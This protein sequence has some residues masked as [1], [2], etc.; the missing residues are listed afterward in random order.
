MAKL[1][2]QYNKAKK[3]IIVKNVPALQDEIKELETLKR[4]ETDPNMKKG[5][6]AQI[7]ALKIKIK[8][9]KQKDPVK[10]SVDYKSYID[11]NRCSFFESSL[12]TEKETLDAVGGFQGLKT[13]IDTYE[14]EGYLDEELYE[15]LYDILSSEMPYGTQRAR[16]GDPDEWIYNYLVRMQEKY[17]S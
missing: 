12:D 2:P 13:T 5:I 10:D 4:G 1:Q 9:Y 6:D 7:K 16:T 8:S 11:K 15:K 14:K 17:S 3:E